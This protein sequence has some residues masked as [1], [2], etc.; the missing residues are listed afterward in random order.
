ML[1]I[2]RTGLLLPSSFRERGW[3]INVTMRI[4]SDSVL[5]RNCFSWAGYLNFWWEM[6]V[7]KQIDHHTLCK[8]P[9][10]QSLFYWNHLLDFEWTIQTESWEALLSDFL[11]FILPTG[12]KFKKN[13]ETTPIYVF[14]NF[15]CVENV[16]K[17]VSNLL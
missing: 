1:T 9:T 3:K 14:V 2:N 4:I 5:M 11:G 15:H 6:K 10:V 7:Y 16:W 13:M 17:Y 12:W 8:R